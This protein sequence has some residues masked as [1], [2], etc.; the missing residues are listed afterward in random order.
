MLR[1][2]ISYEVREVSRK[3]AASIV[4]IGQYSQLIHHKLQSIV[5]A[6]HV[7]SHTRRQCSYQGKA[8]PIQPLK[9]TGG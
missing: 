7:T 4:R 8:I 2:V 9:A 6:L 3:T 5:M 1:P